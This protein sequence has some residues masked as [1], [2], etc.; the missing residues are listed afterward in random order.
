MMGS[1]K[2]WLVAKLGGF[3]DLDDYIEVT[4]KNPQEKHYILTR[5]VK[6]LFNTIDADDILSEDEKGHWRFKGKPLSDAEKGL[7]IAEAQTLMS[8]RLWEILRTD[9]LYQANRKTFLLAR[10][11]SSITAGKL[12][13]YTFDVVSS[14]LKRMLKGQGTMPNA[15]FW[16]FKRVWRLTLLW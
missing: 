12:W 9:A 4:A 11:E 16:K 13:H 7:L 2:N 14:R 6:L 10:D 1:L 8:S 15:D 5:A 3:T